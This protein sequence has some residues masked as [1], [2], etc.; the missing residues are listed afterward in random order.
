MPDLVQQLQGSVKELQKHIT[1]S[2]E[3]FQSG[4]CGIGHQQGRFTFGLL[5]LVTKLSEEGMSRLAGC[6]V[7]LDKV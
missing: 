6:L 5:F 4:W 7:D 2:M 3:W 1:S